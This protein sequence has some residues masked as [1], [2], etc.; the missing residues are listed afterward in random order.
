MI[1]PDH[2]AE[3]RRQH[4]ARGR[5]VTVRRF[6]WSERDP[7]EA[8]AMAD[9]RADEALARVLA[10]ERLERREPKR[11]YN[12]AD[13][14]PIREEVLE[15]HGAQVITRNG[16]GA[17]CLNS[18]DALFA[19]VDVEDAGGPLKPWLPLGVLLALAVAAT[20][21]IG[22]AIAFIVLGLVAV[23]AAWPLA[24][25]LRRRRIARQ[26]GAAAIVEARLRAFLAAH[27]DW[28]LRVY[29]TPRGLRLLATHATFEATAPEVAAFF[30][31]VGADPVYRRMCERQRCFR[32]RLTAKPWRIGMPGRLRP[33]PGVWPVAEDAR[34][35]R[36][37][38]IA[39]YERRAADYAACRF[40]EALGS[41]V[42]APALREVI[43]LHD[44]AT[45]ACVPGLVI[46]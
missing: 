14:V 8:Q 22:K 20:L 2:W 45:R 17:R 5:Q 38:W 42:E 13:G 39:D 6:G 9:A 25:W 34:P 31:A 23:I 10:G 36:D 15:R 24:E 46:A 3:A 44:A 19:D 1:V 26:G 18:P 28:A 43:A 37:A 16:Y 30:E 32:A 11:A 35:R 4:R 27:P 21:A 33:R 29:E 12:G 7:A 40:R 41:G